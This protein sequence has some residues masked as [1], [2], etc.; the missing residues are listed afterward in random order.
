MNTTEQLHKELVRVIKLGFLPTYLVKEATWEGGVVVLK[1]KHL[2]VYTLQG[3]EIRLHA[4]TKET[5]EEV[6]DSLSEGAWFSSA[7][8]WVAAQYLRGY[9]VMQGTGKGVLFALRSADHDAYTLEA[10]QEFTGKD[11]L[12]FINIFNKY[13]HLV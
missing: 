3:P 13:N 4:P 7:A 10:V 11:S 9:T 2:S 1:T 6:K 5:L 8:R 12:S